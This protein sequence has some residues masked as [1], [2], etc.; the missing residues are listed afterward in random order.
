MMIMMMMKVIS[1]CFGFTKLG[2]AQMNGSNIHAAACMCPY[3][4]HVPVSRGAELL[5]CC[6][7]CISI[8]DLLLLQMLPSLHQALAERGCD[9]TRIVFLV[10]IKR[11]TTRLFPAD[12]VIDE[13]A[14]WTEPGWSLF[15]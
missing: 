3:L 10:A 11:H 12:K 6:T 14:G 2:G 7:T 13:Q 9:N 4:P 15:Y 5:P 1:M 8:R